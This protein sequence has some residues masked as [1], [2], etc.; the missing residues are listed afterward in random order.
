MLKII[1]ITAAA[2]ALMV[3]AADAQSG[4]IGARKVPGDPYV[5][6][7]CGSSWA[8]CRYRSNWRGRYQTPQY[9]AAQRRISRN[10]G[11]GNEWKDAC[12]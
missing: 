6:S 1:T 2:T 8:I 5:S 10:C 7:G 12:R 3:G 9:Q 11:R 4:F